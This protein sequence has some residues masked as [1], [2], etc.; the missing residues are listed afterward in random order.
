[1]RGGGSGVQGNP[2]LT[3]HVSFNPT[4]RVALAHQ[5][6]FAVRVP[7]TTQVPADDARRNTKASQHDGESRGKIFAVTLSGGKK[8][9]GQRVLFSQRKAFQRIAVL[10]SEEFF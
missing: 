7:I 6:V 10:L 3:S 4:V 8:K 2:P 5:I 1:M 9:S